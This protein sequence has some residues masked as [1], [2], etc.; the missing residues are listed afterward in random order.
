MDDS[1]QWVQLLRSSRWTADHHHEVS[2]AAAAAWD[3]QPCCPQVVPV[4]FIWGL[5]WSHDGSSG[6]G[7]CRVIGCRCALPTWGQHH[8]V[9]RSHQKTQH[10]LVQLGWVADLTAAAI[11]WGFS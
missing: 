2:Q 5:H 10:A 4:P 1:A 11:V 6:L 8:A 3:R 9:V 7:T